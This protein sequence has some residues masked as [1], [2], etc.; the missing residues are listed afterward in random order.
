MYDK[1]SLDKIQKEDTLY[2]INTRPP[3]NDLRKHILK[4]PNHDLR[5]SVIAKIGVHDIILNDFTHI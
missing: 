5:T 2:Y 1:I 4:W 3:E